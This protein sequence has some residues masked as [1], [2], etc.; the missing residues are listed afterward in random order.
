MTEKFSKVH[1]SLVEWQLRS[2][3]RTFEE[4]TIYIWIMFHIEQK[5]VI[6]T[7][8]YVHDVSD[9]EELSLVM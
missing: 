1:S 4:E 6:K 2:G 8:Q 9:F 5:W 3:L 7:L